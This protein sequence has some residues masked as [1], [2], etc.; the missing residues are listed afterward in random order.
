MLMMELSFVLLYHAIKL[1]LRG[2]TAFS[3]V[4]GQGKTGL[5]TSR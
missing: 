5:V 3:F 1:V 4:L 2:Q